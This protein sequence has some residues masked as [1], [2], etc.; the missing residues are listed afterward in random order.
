[1][2]RK[3]TTEKKVRCIVYISTVGDMQYVNHIVS[4]DERLL[5]FSFLLCRKL[6]WELRYGYKMI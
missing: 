2:K 6:N 3:R 4:Q 1:M 5:G